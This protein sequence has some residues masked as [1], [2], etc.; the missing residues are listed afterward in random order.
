MEKI[1]L[2]REE[3]RGMKG[4][5]YLVA[6]IVSLVM[7]FFGIPVGAIL[8]G[9]MQAVLK[10]S[11]VPVMYGFFLGP[12]FLGMLL[13][14][15][16]VKKSIGAKNHTICEKCKGKMH[17]MT[18]MDAVFQI[19]AAG[20]ET[21]GDAMHYLA[22]N[23]ARVPAVNAIPVGQRGCYVCGYRC[24]KC[25]NRIVRI[26]DFLPER[27]SCIDKETYYFDFAAFSLARGREDFIN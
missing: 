7:G 11:S 2:A 14:F 15:F 3:D 21:Y 16:Y 23:M 22:G 26:K 18:E 10:D 17:P 20:E 12:V 8:S 27:G 24:E 19:P 6:F 13:G 9:V 25:G 1:I 5:S 4:Q